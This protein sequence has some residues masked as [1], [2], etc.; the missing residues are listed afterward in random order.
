MTTPVL[1]PWNFNNN[2]L[3][4]LPEPPATNNDSYAVRV[5]DLKKA[6]LDYVDLKTAQIVGGNKTFTGNTKI[7]GTNTLE[8]GADIVGKEAFAGFI[9]Y[10]TFAPDSLCIVGAGTRA[11]NRKILFFAEGGTQFNGS[12]IGTGSLEFN[13]GAIRLYSSH[14][15]LQ[16]NTFFGRQIDNGSGFGLLTPDA[17][18]QINGG[19]IVADSESIL[20]TPGKG[21]LTVGKITKTGGIV[22]S[23]VT[24]TTDYTIKNTDCTVNGDA[25][26]GNVTLFLPPASSLSS[27][28][29]FK[30]AK[31]DSTANTVSIQAA[32]GD[33]IIGETKRVLNSRW[34]SVVYETDG[35]KTWFIY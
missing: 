8:F 3:F 34:D 1:Q 2:A 28:Q 6:L 25:T 26:T 20:P 19:V 22:V 23:F 13:F 32:V 11:N 24:K 17:E 12:L 18:V 9:G 21:N 5:A 29:Q 27:G 14:N 33:N 16:N 30:T 15:Y 31:V 4:G 35:N 7:R 10:Q